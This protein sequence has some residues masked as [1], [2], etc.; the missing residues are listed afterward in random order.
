MFVRFLVSYIAIID[1]RI[2]TTMLLI[3][4]FSSQLEL[5]ICALLSSTAIALR[6]GI[7]AWVSEYE[8]LMIIKGQLCHLTLKI[9]R[10]RLI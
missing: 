9:K 5:T 10:G 7:G 3:T 6:L 1:R 8:D 4:P 2:L